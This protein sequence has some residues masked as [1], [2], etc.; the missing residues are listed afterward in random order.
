MTSSKAIPPIQ[1]AHNHKW[2]TLIEFTLS[3]RSGSVHLATDLAVGAVQTLNWPVAL[4][5]QLELALTK[6][7]QNVLERSQLNGS[8]EVLIIRVL[9]PEHDWRT[10]ADLQAGDELTEHQM[11]KRQAQRVGRPPSRGW[12]FFLITKSE[13][14]SHG[15]GWHLI[16]MFLYPGGK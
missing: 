2:Q 5:G 6:A 9:I 4:L 8:E 10:W 14:D 15:N 7:I 11:T 1:M 16:E 13:S 3:G 12:G